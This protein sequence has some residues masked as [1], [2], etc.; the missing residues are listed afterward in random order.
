[1]IMIRGCARN[2]DMIRSKA[3]TKGVRHK[4]VVSSDRG[5]SLYRDV[6][7]VHAVRS[8]L[9][10]IR[11]VCTPTVSA[12]SCEPVSPR[13]RFVQILFVEPVISRVVIRKVG[14][15]RARHGTDYVTNY[16]SNL[17][18]DHYIYQSTCCDQRSCVH[19]TGTVRS[20]SGDIPL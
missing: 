11:L 13:C 18:G 9:I 3:S 20:I 16:R 4:G 14:G 6:R 8:L 10:G 12:A 17:N 7:W 2:R 19:S 5:L 15:L 1:M